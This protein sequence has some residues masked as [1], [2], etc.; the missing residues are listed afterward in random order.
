MNNYK[1]N[2]DLFDAYLNGTMSDT[3]KSAFETQLKADAN[4]RQEFSIHKELVAGLQHSGSLAD[5]EFENALKHLSDQEM[6]KITERATIR[7][8]TIPQGRV[9]PLRKVYS[10]VAVA[11]AVV[12]IAGAGGYQYH[13]IQ[14]RNRLCDAIFTAG[15]NPDMTLTRS[16]DQRDSEAYSEAIN[17][18]KNGETVDAISALEK[19]YTEANDE[20][21]I[22]Y[23]TS[24][25]YAYVKAHDLD[26]AWETINS[27]KSIS[28]QLYG[29]TPLELESLIQAMSGQ[30]L[31]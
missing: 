22:E 17:R 7:N 15:F 10:W 21:R 6:E 4:L 27:V 14:T 20:M 30:N 31:K 5:K 23:G 24:L 28:Q 12:M 26:K 19:L 3:D 8:K 11:A 18:L 16:G 2:I 9:V 25:A 1:D 13:Q 29:E